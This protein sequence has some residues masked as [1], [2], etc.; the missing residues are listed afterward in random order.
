MVGQPYSLVAWVAEPGSSWALPLDLTRIP[1]DQTDRPVAAAQI[2]RLNDLRPPTD[3]ALWIYV[4]DG[5]Y[6]NVHFWQ[7]LPGGE[8]HGVVTRLRRDRVFYPAP[9]SYAGRG[10]PRQHGPRFAFREPPTWGPLSGKKP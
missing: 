5:N 8:Q 2:T 4:F 9:D 10:R 3:R 6:G 7:A 1:S